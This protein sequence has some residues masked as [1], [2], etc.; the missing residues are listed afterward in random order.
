MNGFLG[1]K[2][3]VEAARS[4][5]ASPDTLAL[6]AGSE[7]IFVREAVAENSRTPSR[8]LEQLVPSSLSAEDDIRI[9]AALLANPTLQNGPC[10]RIAELMVDIASNLSPRDFYAMLL[11]ERLFRHPSTPKEAF[12]RLLE[13]RDFPQHLRGRVACEET[14]I[15]ALKLLVL[16]KS[17]RVRSRAI[18]ALKRQGDTQKSNK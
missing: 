3:E 15:D 12:V 11:V 10:G 8:L 18:K 7:Y 14:N 9:S 2:S 5:S 16:D 4:P 17:E 1:P 6:L 13:S